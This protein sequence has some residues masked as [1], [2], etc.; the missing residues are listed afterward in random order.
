MKRH[1]RAQKVKETEEIKTPVNLPPA[2]SRLLDIVAQVLLR[3]REKK[4]QS[5]DQPK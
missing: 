3:R 4:S 2:V 5:L 1:K